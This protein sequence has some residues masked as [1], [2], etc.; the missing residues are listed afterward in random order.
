MRVNFKNI[1]FFMIFH[2]WFHWSSCF[3]SLS[4][5]SVVHSICNNND[6]FIDESQRNFYF[7]YY[8]FQLILSI[9]D[10]RSVNFFQI[11]NF[12]PQIIVLIWLLEV[13]SCN[14]DNSISFVFSER[15]EECFIKRIISQNNFIS[16]FLK[17]FDKWRESKNKFIFAS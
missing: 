7:L 5:W 10:Q 2:V 15:I 1:L 16:L 9:F 17:S 4:I 12:F 13:I 8:I 11:F 3:K 6:R 14:I